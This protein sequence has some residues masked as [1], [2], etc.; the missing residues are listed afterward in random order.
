M[1]RMLVLSITMIAL[2]LGVVWLASIVDDSAT[3][4]CPA[5]R[6]AREKRLVSDSVSN[7]GHGPTPGPVGRFAKL[8]RVLHRHAK[9]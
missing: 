7:S 9:D 1:K 4:M 8:G 6:P 5:T 2:A 3:V